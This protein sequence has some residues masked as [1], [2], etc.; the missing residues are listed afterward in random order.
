MIIDRGCRYGGPARK[1]RVLVRTYRDDLTWKTHQLLTEE[2][3]RFCNQYG[4][5][6]DYNYEHPDRVFGIVPKGVRVNHHLANLFAGEPPWIATLS[7]SNADEPTRMRID[8]HGD[9]F[10]ERITGL[11][12]LLRARLG[13][14]AE[15]AVATPYP[16]RAEYAGD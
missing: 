4:Y 10:A 11:A 9:S 8:I 12:E 6:T 7:Y 3:Y 2:G 16:K 1:E 14:I 15:V 13:I 5:F